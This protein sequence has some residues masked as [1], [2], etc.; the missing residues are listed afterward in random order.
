MLEVSGGNVSSLWEKENVDH[1]AKK[2]KIIGMRS[3][4]GLKK[5]EAISTQIVVMERLENVYVVRMGREAYEHKLVNL[6]NKMPDINNKDEEQLQTTNPEEQLT[7]MSVTTP[8][9]HSLI[10]GSRITITFQYI[11]LFY[12]LAGITP[13]QCKWYKCL[14]SKPRRCM[15]ACVSSQLSLLS[16][17][18]LSS[19]ASPSACSSSPSALPDNHMPSSS[20]GA[21]R[22]TRTV[23]L[24]MRSTRKLFSWQ[25]VINIFE[26]PPFPSEQIHC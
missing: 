2:A 18:D 10:I 26:H 14:T 1:E 11:F 21:P 25:H 6:V 12:K 22:P 19:Y 4:I 9:I 20:S 13:L 23:D 3:V 16:A 7:P 8:E 15:N 17:T 5:I 24:S